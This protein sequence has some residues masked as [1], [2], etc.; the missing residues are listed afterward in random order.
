M[1]FLE[2]K[3]AAAREIALAFGVPPMLLGIPGDNTYSNFKEA[4]A[5]FWRATVLPLTAKIAA[6]LGNWLAP[7]FED[8]A[9]AGSGGPASCVSGSTPTR[10]TR[11]PPTARRSGSAWRRRTS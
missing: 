1:D 9:S 10:W 4:N 6:A 8:A 11:C 2:A 5:A 3:N 7:S